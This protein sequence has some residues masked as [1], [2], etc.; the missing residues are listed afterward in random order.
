MTTRDSSGARLHFMGE[1]ITAPLKAADALRYIADHQR[2]R[3]GEIDAVLTDE[4]KITLVRR[5]VRE[6][7]LQIAAQ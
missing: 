6:G 4:S 5:L 3:V 1:T 2:F 7:L